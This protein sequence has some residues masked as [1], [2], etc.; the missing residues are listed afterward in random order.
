MFM[1]TNEASRSH[2][3]AT[4]P[5]ILIAVSNR[6]RRSVLCV[7]CRC[8]RSAWLLAAAC[9]WAPLV[10]AEDLPTAND[11]FER[12][13]YVT[14][15]ELYETLA[16]QGEAE[17]QFQLG[18][19]YE[20]GL[21]TDV[22]GQMAQRYYEQAAEQQSPQALDAL[23]T[24]HLK[25]EGVIQNFKESLRLFQRAA[26]QGYP[27]AQH[28]LGIAYADGKG[29]FRDPVKAHM[30]FNLAAANGYAEAAASR[31]RLAASMAQSEI[32]RAQDNA[33]KC[34][35]QDFVGC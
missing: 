6:F 34:A 22:D 2:K 19:M 11:A 13:E 31:E 33:M 21:G 30:W 26:E 1:P 17:A 12:G 9:I 18:L 3:L 10:S 4:Y 7:G 25:G 14:A 20:Q 32:A 29:T 5:M 24:L 8:L 27:R 15:L 23:G 35:D 16:A 28:N